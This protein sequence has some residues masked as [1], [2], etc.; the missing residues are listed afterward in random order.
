MKIN[1]KQMLF[2]K[3]TIRKYFLEEKI[4]QKTFP[5]KQVDKF[6]H[7]HDYEKESEKRN[8]THLMVG[9]KIHIKVS[10]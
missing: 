7:W 2:K 6:D 8:V 3:F 1:S 10:L 5:Y 4:V 9:K